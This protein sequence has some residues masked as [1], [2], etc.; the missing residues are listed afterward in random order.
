MPRF[1]FTNRIT[2]DE[3]RT[4]RALTTQ[5]SENPPSDQAPCG[6]MRAILHDDP[7]ASCSAFWG[8]V[9]PRS[10]ATGVVRKAIPPNSSAAHAASELLGNT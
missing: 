1:T 4:S 3:L 9:S 7:A 5:C 6:R 10:N 2:S 8:D